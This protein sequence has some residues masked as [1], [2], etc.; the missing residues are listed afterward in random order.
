MRADLIKAMHQ[1]F[2]ERGTPPECGDAPA[3]RRAL[4]QSLLGS[5][6]PGKI[7]LGIELASGLQLKELQAT[8]RAVAE[9]TATASPQRSA[10]LTSL[11]AID[12]SRN[13]PLIADAAGQDPRR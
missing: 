7:D 6:D 3:R 12:P 13:E 5:G 2:Q 8:L 1:G 11:M 10:A 9:R 4:A